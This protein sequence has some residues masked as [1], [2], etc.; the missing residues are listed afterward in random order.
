MRP[1]ALL[2]VVGWLLALPGDQ[3]QFQFQWLTAAAGTE[4]S[5]ALSEML[6]GSVRLQ[7]WLRAPQL[8]IVTSVMIYRPGGLVEYTAT[9]EE[10]T[11]AEIAELENDLT[12]AL[13]A[14]TAATFEQFS[15]VEK[16]SVTPGSVVNIGRPGSIVVGRFKGLREIEKTV[17]LGGLKARMDGTITAAAIILD[18]EFDRGAQRRLLRTHELG[19]ALGYSHVRSRPSIMN[20]HIGSDMNDLDR[21]AAAIAFRAPTVVAAR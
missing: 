20:L 4:D 10:L 19:H 21:E 16:E 12:D 1:L 8:K 11:E 14:L 17:G 5:L 9:S 3:Q 2:I 18:S 7:R 6:G 15:S 13:R